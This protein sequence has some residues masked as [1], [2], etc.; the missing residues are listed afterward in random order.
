MRVWEE[1]LHEIWQEVATKNGR[2]CLPDIPIIPMSFMVI[3]ENP[4]IMA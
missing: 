2:S 4:M 3:L 1:S